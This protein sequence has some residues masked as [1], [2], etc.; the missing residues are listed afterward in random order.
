MSSSGIRSD[1]ISPSGGGSSGPSGTGTTDRLTRWTAAS[2]LAASQWQEDATNGN[3]S[4]QGAALGTRSVPLIDLDK[5]NHTG[6]FLDSINSYL[7]TSVGT[8]L[9]TQ[10]TSDPEFHLYDGNN[11]VNNYTAFRTQGS[12]GLVITTKGNNADGVLKYVSGTTANFAELELIDGVASNSWSIIMSG[13]LTSGTPASNPSV[14]FFTGPGTNGGGGSAV[15]D[16]VDAMTLNRGGGWAV[17]AEW[18]RANGFTVN[19]RLDWTGCSGHSTA[20]ASTTITGTGTNFLVDFGLF[21]SVALSSAPTVFGLITAITDDNTMTVDTALGDGSSQTFVRR[22]APFRTTDRNRVTCG[23]V[24]ANGN[25]AV[26]K[27]SLA[28]NATDGFIYIPSCAGAP[29]GV[30]STRTG[31]APLVIDSTNN[32]LY[33]R[34]GGAWKAIT[35]I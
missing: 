19:A 7:T 29:T 16:M 2:V 9:A 22:Q 35:G 14:M 23:Y 5:T 11:N 13:N 15:W 28:T 12:I 34:S 24:D 6:F 1:I 26:G 4:Y 21:D 3:W 10:V 32:K 27:A 18:N 25:N 31:Y 33:Y 8:K 20:N 30:P 17:G